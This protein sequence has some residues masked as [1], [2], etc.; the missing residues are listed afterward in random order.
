MDENKLSTIEENQKIARG[1]SREKA[2]FQGR[3]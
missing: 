1:G 2:K 3:I